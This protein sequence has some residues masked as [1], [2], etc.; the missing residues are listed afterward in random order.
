MTLGE[1]AAVLREREP[2]E[3]AVM[4]GESPQD[5]SVAIQLDPLVTAEEYANPVVGGEKMAF[6]AR[7]KV[8]DVRKLHRKIG[9]L[10]SV[11]AEMPQHN[12]SF[13]RATEQEEVMILVKRDPV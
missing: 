2:A 10:C 7:C 1:Q 3:L 13:F 5:H 8:T 12:L 9:Y 11:C 6:S 4:N